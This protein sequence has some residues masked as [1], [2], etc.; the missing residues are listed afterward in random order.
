MVDIGFGPHQELMAHDRVSS[1]EFV[2]PRQDVLFPVLIQAFL[3][4]DP[5]GLR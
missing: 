4:I 2:V 1:T 3:G 5:L